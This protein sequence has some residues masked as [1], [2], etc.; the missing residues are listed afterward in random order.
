M[1]VL[2]LSRVR[3]VILG[4]TLLA[5]SSCSFRHRKYENPIAAETEQPDKILF[6]KAIKDLEKGRYEIARITLNTLI[7]TYDSSEF[8]A[9]SKLAIADAWYREGGLRGYSQAEAEYKDFILFYPT[10][11]E[12]AESQMRICDIHIKQMEKPDRD[13]KQALLAEQE[14]K[15]ILVQFPNS[16]FIADASQRLRN[17]QETLGQHEFGIGEFYAK[18]GSNNAAA[19]RLGGVADQYPLFS[20]ADEALWLEGESLQRL[21]P[22][23]RDQA[24]DSYTRI[25]RDYPL[26]EYADRAKAKLRELE[27]A[28]PDADPAALARMQFELDNRV[29][30]GIFHRTFGF[31]RRGPDTWTA[32]KQGDPQMN[33]PARNIPPLVPPPGAAGWIPG[34]RDGC[35][36]DELLGAGSESRRAAARSGQAQALTPGRA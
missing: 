28:V 13:Q 2:N 12:A 21:G 11:E 18:R 33:P 6:D 27:L 5:V 9:K 22:Q 8:L 23:F 36:G 19:N 15:Q 10:M 17:I 25:V 20:K 35:S 4:L 16:K 31:M 26:S 7:N 14:C 3:F 29:E 32:A 34:R 1:K 30:P 24:G